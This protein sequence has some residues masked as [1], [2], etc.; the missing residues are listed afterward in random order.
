MNPVRPPRLVSG[1]TIGVIA[2]SSSIRD[3]R[4]ETGIAVIEK[5]G[6]NV[7]RGDHLSDR[8]GYLAGVDRA[9][10]AELTRMFE[11]PDVNA[12][13]CV[14]GGYGACRMVE[15]V[16]WGVVMRKP[17]VFV[18]YSDITT[19]HLAME[20]FAGL[21][22]IH[23]PV[24]VSHGQRLSE[25]CS[26]TFWRM[27]RE[28]KPFGLLDTGKAKIQTVRAGRVTGRLA[29]GCLSILA[30]A[31]GTPEAPDFA[32][33][34][35][36]LE[37]VGEPVYRIDRYLVQLKRAGLL[38][39]AAGFV[40]GVVTGWRAEEKIEDPVIT[41]EDVWRDHI[42]PLGKPAI[43]GFP[44]GHEPNP[45]TLPLGCLAELDADSGTLSILEPAVS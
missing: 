8:H 45:L 6:F 22:T 32:G 17:K 1:M 34:I 11:R 5:A 31:V 41:P 18:G 28:P 43:A 25:T 15:Y 39:Q 13:F 12:V 37:D 9:R 38:Q 3:D 2:P 10:G 42:L 7:I 35:V 4:L 24:V 40:I 26:S 14:R 16:D 20:R 23:G 36:L 29:G 30:G 33:R 19:L 27:V 44:F 21:V